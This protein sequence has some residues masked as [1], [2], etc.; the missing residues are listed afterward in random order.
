MNAEKSKR[1]IQMAD[2]G[3]G[4]MAASLGLCPH[5]YDEDICHDRDD[6]DMVECYHDQRIMLSRCGMGPEMMDDINELAMI[7]KD[8]G[9]PD[10]A[11]NWKGAYER[12]EN[13]SQQKTTPDPTGASH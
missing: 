10:F 5:S 12:A 4:I 9:C 11:R 7:A 1:R 8:R 6:E 2:A 13:L 3:K